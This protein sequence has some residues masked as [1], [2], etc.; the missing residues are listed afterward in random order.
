MIARQKTK[1]LLIGASSY[2]GARLFVDL[3]EEFSIVGSYYSNP[4]YKDF[5]K[6]DITNKD[7]V[8]KVFEKY[9]P[10][11]VVHAANNA[12]SSWCQKN[13]HKAVELNQKATTYIIKAANE[14][15]AKVIYIS[16]FAA[17]KPVN[18]YG[19]TKAASEK[20]VQGAEKGYL[21]LRPSLIVGFSPNTVND[22]P[23]NRIL[24]NL[25]GKT[26]AV[27]DTSWKFQPTYL[28]HISEVIKVCLN[29]NLNQKIIPIAIKGLKSRFD[30]AKDILAY[31]NIP[32]K[33]IKEANYFPVFKEDLGC[34]K[35]FNLSFYDYQTMI[36][37]IVEEIKSK[38]KEVKK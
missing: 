2:V 38:R 12:S 27:Y 28:G 1:I 25:E 5:I 21:I 24:R 15:G 4:L 7:Q 3:K 26:E 10:E 18:L 8:F 13:P 20:I 16:S 11:S 23:F 9:K 14:I 30:L 6:L 19:K 35:Q 36:K 34:L 29:K 32:V 17:I 22:R 37:T 33:P 31:F